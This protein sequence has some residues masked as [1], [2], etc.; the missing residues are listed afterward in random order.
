M[1]TILRHIKKR[2]WI[3]ILICAAFAIVSIWTDMEI[4]ERMRIITVLLQTEGSSVKEIMLSGLYMLMFAV[5]GFACTLM[6][7]FLSVKEG[8]AIATRIRGDLFDK[9]ISFSMPEMSRFSTSSLIMRCTEDVTQIQTFLV[10]GTVIILKAPVTAVVGFARISGVNPVWTFIS[11]VVFAVTVAFILVITIVLKPL[12]NKFRQKMDELTMMSREHLEG[13]KVIHA[14]RSYMIHKKRFED[15]NSETAALSSKAM[16]GISLLSPFLDTMT[17]LLNILIFLAGAYIIG[18][19]QSGSRTGLF[20]DMVTFSSYALLVM[21][22]FVQLL[23]MYMSM[24]QALASIRRVEE[25][26][27]TEPSIRDGNEQTAET[28][29]GTVELSHVSFK[30]PNSGDY[31][32]EDINICA[33]KGQTIAI[34]GA[35]GSGK[36]SIL[37]LIPRFYDV[38]EG[39][40]KVNGR[41]V[42]DYRIKELREKLGYIPQKSILFSGSVMENIAYGDNGRFAETLQVVKRAAQLGQAKEFIEKEDDGYNAR[43]AEGG[44]NYS[45]GQRQ[46]LTISRAIARD[47]EIYLFDDSFSALDFKT[48]KELRNGLREAA[49][50]ATILIVAQRIG[51]IM[52]ADRIYVVDDGKIVGCGTHEELIRDCEVY[53]EIAVSQGIL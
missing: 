34:I 30:Y 44:S 9:I 45:G 20:A 25:V 23:I 31:V 7:A 6:T 29:E 3:Y 27:V 13:I 17:N 28:E 14:F 35:T 52:S 26:L 47:P 16:F 2:E 37:N 40:V 43:V 19:A 46:R 1:K 36:T 38:T 53:K 18:S 33:K 39:S 49:G 24:V 41:D 21:G 42:R 50:Y 15:P 8:A 5:L 22:A 32:L 10:T 48:D 51:T 4:P 11:G 12:I